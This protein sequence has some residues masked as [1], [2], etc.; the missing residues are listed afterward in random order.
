MRRIRGLGAY[1]LGA[2]LAF[3]SVSLL[4]GCGT[5]ADD[6]DALEYCDVEPLFARHCTKCHNDSD[7]AAGPMPLET[8]EQV[9]DDKAKVA[10]WVEDGRMPD[11]ALPVTITQKERDMIVEWA[12]GPAIQ[13]HCE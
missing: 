12:M 4:S 10:S 1:G 5:E 3:S 2:L 6:E 11:K 13:G 9:F 7:H 8:Y